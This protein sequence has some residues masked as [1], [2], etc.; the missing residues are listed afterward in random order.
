M[1]GGERQRV[2]WKQQYEGTQGIIFVIDVTS[3]FGEKQQSLDEL[4]KLNKQFQDSI[5][6]L[7]AISKIDKVETI[8][9][10]AYKGTLTR[11][12]QLKL[13]SRKYN[14]AKLEV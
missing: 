1:A 8:E 5:P 6:L 14:Y 2:F 12:L 4:E 11:L 10:I 9:W 13:P 3:T 7:V